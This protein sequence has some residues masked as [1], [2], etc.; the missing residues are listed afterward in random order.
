MLRKYCLTLVVVLSCFS[1]CYSN[2]AIDSLKNVV[3]NSTNDSLKVEALLLLSK[4]EARHDAHQSR[5]YALEALSLAQSNDMKWGMGA[6]YN[7]IGMAYRREGAFQTALEETVKGL[8]IYTYI[9]D[10]TG[11]SICLNNIGI[12]YEEQGSQDQALKYYL[13]SLAIDEA[14][15]D[16]KGVS[17]SLN[18]IGL[19][20]M[21]LKEFDNAVD[22][23]EQSIAIK[24][25]LGNKKGLAYSYLNLGNA[26]LSQQKHSK[27]IKHYQTSLGIY[28]EID[29]PLGIARCYNN[30]ALVEQ[31]MGNSLGALEL[32]EKALKLKEELGNKLDILRTLNGLSELHYILKDYDRALTRL[33]RAEEM[34][35]V[36]G[37]RETLSSTYK[38]KSKAYVGKR[39]FEQAFK[40]YKKHISIKDSLFSLEKQE[41]IER[42]KNT[43][44]MGNLEQKNLV[45]KLQL[46]EAEERSKRKE[47][48]TNRREAKKEAEAAQK[49][50]M[51]Y[52]SLL[53]LLLVSVLVI[54]VLRGNRQK[55]K[56]NTELALKNDVIE[57]KNK[58]ITSSI[59]YARQIQE[60][61]LP[62]MDQ[63]GKSLGDFLVY[64][65]P[66]DVVSGDFYWFADTGDK[67]IVAA[68]DC[69]GHGVPGSMVSML[70][71]HV[72]NHLILF[73]GI[74]DPGEVLT[75]A[76]EHILNE[77][78]KE[79]LNNTR[80]PDGMDIALCIMDK[81]RQ[82]LEF[83]GANNPLLLIRNGEESE[84]RGDRTPIGGQTPMNHPFV[85]H[86]IEIQ[87]GDRIYMYSDGY[88]DQFGGP[89][90]KK[91]MMNRFKKLLLDKHQLPFT[92]QH[93]VL[94]SELQNWQGDQER[95]DD[96]LV[97]GFSV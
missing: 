79:V 59:M 2:N 89:Q 54:L 52:S 36:V 93:D 38:W 25:E 47:V 49:D 13:K 69:T 92:D 39:D 84:Y 80:T 43:H 88:A 17:Y 15:G 11:M 18:N 74:T 44:E 20:Y 3:V 81:S 22:Y 90:G 4:A 28:V 68:A 5:Q 57:Q 61:I 33:D 78:R 95:I 64:F 97:V 42:L 19:I 96:V 12:I 40:Y 46:K 91:F 29:N 14:L 83:S 16:K 32:M 65:D 7:R 87:T 53:V 34:G 35:N 77:F 31:G 26:Y 55:Q 30:M 66:K 60:S 73:E 50:I 6:S 37:A 27:A 70:C 48:E 85:T 8:D 72:L 76:N 58:D 82:F 75:K 1:W 94:K 56:T 24:K 86:K 41:A 23:L 10:S 51:L 62:S 9:K 67:I 63:M 45:A 21:Y 71:N